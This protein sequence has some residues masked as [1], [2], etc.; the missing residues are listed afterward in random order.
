MSVITDHVAPPMSAAKT[1]TQRGNELRQRRA[2]QGLQEVRGVWA[3]PE[4]HAAIKKYAVTLTRA[5]DDD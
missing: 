5:R 1:S 2:A 4:D 3:H